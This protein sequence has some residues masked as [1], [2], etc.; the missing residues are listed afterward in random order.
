MK[1]TVKLHRLV[2]VTVYTKYVSRNSQ[3][4]ETPNSHYI[5]LSKFSLL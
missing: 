1:I 3:N 4:L 2:G 5:L